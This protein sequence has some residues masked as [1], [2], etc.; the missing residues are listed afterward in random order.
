MFYCNCNCNFVCVV[1]VGLLSEPKKN[2][3]FLI[4]SVPTSEPADSSIDFMTQYNSVPESLIRKHRMKCSFPHSFGGLL[5]VGSGGAI[6]AG[7]AT[8]A[9]PMSPVVPVIRN[10]N[11][12]S[13]SALTT[14]GGSINA[15]A[16][17]SNLSLS[18]LQ[19]ELREA[20]STISTLLSQIAE[21]KK[22]SSVHTELN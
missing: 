16:S 9:A 5:S 3:K 2:D 18:A 10:D 17:D 8:G 1:L 15:G 19:M 22:S 4:N 13:P 14:G 7:G 21:L 6:N 20:Q 11:M 12:G